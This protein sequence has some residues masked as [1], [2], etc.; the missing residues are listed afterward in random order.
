MTIFLQGLHG[1]AE[2]DADVAD[3]DRRLAATIGEVAGGGA[4]GDEL[5]Q[6]L[7][8]SVRLHDPIREALLMTSSRG[9][10]RGLVIGAAVAAGGIAVAAAVVNLAARKLQ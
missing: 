5:R 6:R 1:I 2:R 9:F 8:D 7:A 4:T 10:R 3:L